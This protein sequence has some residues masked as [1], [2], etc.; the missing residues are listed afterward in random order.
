[1]KVCEGSVGLDTPGGG[2]GRGTV[3]GAGLR[4]AHFSSALNLSELF[5]S[6]KAREM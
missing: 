6:V 4:D 2:E 1:M 3:L 5:F